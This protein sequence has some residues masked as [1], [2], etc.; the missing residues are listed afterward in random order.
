MTPAKNFA[1]E[2]LERQ[3]A[4]AATAENRQ[5]FETLAAEMRQKLNQ[6]TPEKQP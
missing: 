5:R 1:L 3:A 2:F 6:P 4:T